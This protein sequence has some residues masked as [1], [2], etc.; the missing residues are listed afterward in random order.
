VAVA[1]R[2]RSLTACRIWIGWA[3]GSVP[4][5]LAGRGNVLAEAGT[6]WIREV[7]LPEGCLA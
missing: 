2:M 7:A 4:A 3:R 1:A 5:Q 6:S